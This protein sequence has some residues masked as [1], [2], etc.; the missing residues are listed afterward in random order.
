MNKSI[1][2]FCVREHGCSMP[3]GVNNLCT[4]KSLVYNLNIGLLE[5]FQ[6]LDSF[7]KLISLNYFQ[8]K[9]KSIP[10]PR[11]STQ[12]TLTVHTTHQSR[13]LSFLILEGL[14]IRFDKTRAF[15]R[16]SFSPFIV[17]QLYTVPRPTPL[18]RSIHFY[19][20]LLPLPPPNA[21]GVPFGECFPRIHSSHRR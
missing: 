18:N 8:W 7:L 1:F 3:S 19:R 21:T 13:S 10:N 17:L 15:S 5:N 6:I 12:S 20:N 4:E 9:K 16:A 11:N 14:V 2:L